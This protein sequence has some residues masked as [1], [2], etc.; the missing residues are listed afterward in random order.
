MSENEKEDSKNPQ[1]QSGKLL[2]LVRH[3]KSSWK[4]LELSD[5]DRPLNKRGLRDAP[6][7]GHRLASKYSA[8]DH[9]ASS[10]AAR[11]WATAKLIANAWNFPED[12]L[13]PLPAAYEAS[14]S[15]LLGIVS[16][17]PS[18]A[19]SAVLAAHNPSTTIL[20]NF[21][22]GSDIPNVPTCG[23]AVIHFPIANWEEIAEGGGELVEYDFPK[24]LTGESS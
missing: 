22:T 14:A 19:K 5:F 8:P 10:P 1:P 3:A 20:V 9:F 24:N 2:I 16:E 18:E 4:N 7:M 12:K 6:E 15:T 13:L 23:V 17:F 11:A 21:L